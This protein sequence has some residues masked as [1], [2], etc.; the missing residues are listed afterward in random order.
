M[1]KEFERIVPRLQE[2]IMEQSFFFVG[3]A[4]LS[5]AGSVNISPKGLDSLRV[6]G[7]RCVTYR[8]L[9][10]SGNETAAHLLENGRITLLFCSFSEKP[11]LLRL[12]G[13]GRAVDVD[14]EEGEELRA[15][16]AD[17]EIGV[18]QYVVVDV[19]RI[20]TSCGYG[21]PISLGGF[22]DRDLLHRWAQKKGPEGLESYREA[23]NGC[24]IDGL[25]TRA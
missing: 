5:S 14:S 25:P 15:L 8:D 16:F 24:S 22:E 9:T 6:L 21:V 18:R 10:G 4:A 13:S 7:P 17:D 1:A 20:R 3:T 11:N 2:L 12:Y 23:W 19:N